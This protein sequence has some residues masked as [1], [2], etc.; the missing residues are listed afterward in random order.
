MA[1][2]TAFV[3]SYR[4]EYIE[5]YEQHQSL[6]RET[7]TTEAVFKG[8]TAVFLVVGSGS[9]T[10]ATRGTNGLI[11][12]RGDSETQNSCTLQEWHKLDCAA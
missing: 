6:L 3:T 2:D 11:T 8:N 7:V 12:A 1:T 5:A 10:A 9:A 4:E